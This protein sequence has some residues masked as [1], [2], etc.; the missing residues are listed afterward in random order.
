MSGIALSIQRQTSLSDNLIIH[1]LNT[2]IV[3]MVESQHSH[4]KSH[5]IFY[6]GLFAHL[7]FQYWLVSPVLAQEE[8]Q[9]PYFN[10]INNKKLE[11]IGHQWVTIQDSLGFMWFGGRQGLVRYDA[12]EFKP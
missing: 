1:S 7:I 5:W 9:A 12:Y 10:H 2:F 8:S 3:T 6:L 11:A 4:K